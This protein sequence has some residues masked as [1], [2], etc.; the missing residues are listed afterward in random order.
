MRES[1]LFEPI[2]MWLI[3]KVGCEE[4]HAEVLNIDVLGLSGNTNIIVE[5]KTRFSFKLMEQ[6][7]DRMKYAPYVYIAVPRPKGFNNPRPP[8][9]VEKWAKENKV[10][11]LFINL[12]SSPE[13][14]V[15]VF[16]AAHFNH[17]FSKERRNRKF[18]IRSEINYLTRENVGGLKSGEVQTEYKAMINSIKKYLRHAKKHDQFIDRNSDGLLEIRS[19]DNNCAGV[20]IVRS[21]G[22]RTIEQILENCET[23]YLNP[24]P[25]LFR[26]LRKEWN[27]SWCQVTKYN[28]KHYF[29][30]KDPI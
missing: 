3:N 28:G 25:S 30:Y 17:L 10:G 13:Y 1:D 4:V 20:E 6:A 7:E 12:E 16:S 21:R 29:N 14:A 22:D 19:D 5:M 27:K 18:D 15:E 2:K 26:T 11:I 8:K 23:T 24:K 9:I